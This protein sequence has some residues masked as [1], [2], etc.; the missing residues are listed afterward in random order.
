MLSSRLPMLVRYGVP[1]V[2]LGNIVLFIL[3][4]TSFATS[5]EPKISLGQRLLRIPALFNFSLSN[6]IHDMWLARVYPLA[7]LI[8]F[9]SG[10]WPYIKLVAMLGCWITPPWLLSTRKRELVLMALDSLGKW[11]LID[12]Y[13]MT[14]MMVAFHFHVEIPTAVGS[15]APASLVELLV[16]AKFG[17]VVFVLATMLSLGTGHVIVAIH[18]HIERAE[19]VESALKGNGEAD[20][21]VALR[22]LAFP[23]TWS[24]GSRGVAQAGIAVL[25]VVSLGL[26]C[27][28]ISIRSLMFDIQGLAGWALTIIKQNPPRVYSLIEMALAVPA[29]SEHPWSFATLL[30]VGTLFATAVCV[31]IAHLCALLFLWLWPLRYKFQR[32]VFVFTE[33][34]NA[35]S[36]I[37]VYTISVIAALF[38]LRQFAQWIVGDRCDMI[39]P[40]LAKWFNGPLA[41]NPV[42]FDVVAEVL[43][44][45]WILL[46]A[47][48]AYIFAAM[49]VMRRCHAALQERESVPQI[50]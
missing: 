21:P 49:V 18:R 33:V 24:A 48:C 3:S 23:R 29:S 4:N 42:C 44:G 41:G 46:A 20:E 35:W 1:F 45:T 40:I 11:S 31:P 26:I 43:T 16:Q 28:G 14:L 15:A 32:R 7:I 27:V 13:V 17:F 47:C 22:S 38:Q 39:N 12:A 36:A 2:V 5:V 9:F 6:T 8:G 10:A 34:L 37:E 25:L 30:I 50:N 19:R